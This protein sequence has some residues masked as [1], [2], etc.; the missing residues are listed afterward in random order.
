MHSYADT[1]AFAVDA[2]PADLPADVAALVAPSITV[3]AGPAGTGVEPAPRRVELLLYRADTAT[4][5]PAPP[6][7]G[8]HRRHARAS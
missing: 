1:V 3:S 5:S 4:V 2:G 8:K 6:R 7:A